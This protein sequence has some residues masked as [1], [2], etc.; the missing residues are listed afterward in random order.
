MDSSVNAPVKACNPVRMTVQ[1]TGTDALYEG[2]AVCLDTDYGTATAVDGRRLNYAT[3]PSTGNSGAFCGVADRN[4]S[5]KA[6]GQI[7]AVNAPGSQGVKVALGVDTV[8][9]VGMLTFQVG[10]GS[11]AGR[12]VKGGYPGRGSIY[13]RQTVTAVIEAGMTGAWSLAVDGITLTVSSTT[14]LAAGDT[15]ILLGGEQESA[16]KAINPG[17]Y[18]VL[19]ITSGTVL[20]LA[21]SAV[22][23]TPDAAVTCTGYAF[24]GNPT[25]QADLLTGDESGGVEFVSI[26]NAG[27][28]AQPHM[29]GGVSY[30]CGGVT[31]AADADIVLADGVNLGDKK[32]V[33]CLGTLT[34]STTVVDL[35]TAGITLAGGALAEINAI[36]AA[37]D[38]AYLVWNGLW[39]TEMVVGGATE[40]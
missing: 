23:A 21:S 3:R 4:Y 27:N 29:V 28:A 39:R 18:S 37:L 32:G 34:T 6:G 1:Y 17:R 7:I 8:I 33:V 13:P 38:A 36:D 26:L 16:T 19:S 30:I 20:V 2:E 31:L 40:A 22:V 35:A 5:A 14:G 11:G 24:N 25:C 10:G 12:F 9:N 15:V